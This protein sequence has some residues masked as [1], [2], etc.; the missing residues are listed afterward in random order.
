LSY[1]EHHVL[2]RDELLLAIA[3]KNLRRVH[4]KLFDFT[5]SLAGVQAQEA[6]VLL[7]DP[8]GAVS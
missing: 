3:G 8:G 5:F 2:P 1:F 4:Q 7:R 6:D